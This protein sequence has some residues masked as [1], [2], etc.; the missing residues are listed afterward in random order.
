MS[1]LRSCFPKIHQT[2]NQFVQ[3]E[4]QFIHLPE[5]WITLRARAFDSVFN[6]EE[7]KAFGCSSARS[8]ERPIPCIILTSKSA[9]SSAQGTAAPPR[10]MA[11]MSNGPVVSDGTWVLTIYVTDLNIRRQFRVK[12]DMHIGGVMLRLVEDLDITRDWSDHALW[13]PQ[14]YRWLTHTRSTLDQYGVAADSMLQFTPMHKLARIQLPDLQCITM[15]VDFSV[16][17]FNAVIQL[18]KELG[19]R[20]PEELSLKRSIEPDFLSKGYPHALEKRA[21][22]SNI[23]QKRST[24]HSYSA[25]NLSLP[26]PEPETRQHYP[27]TMNSSLHSIQHASSSLSPASKHAINGM[28]TPYV[29]NVTQSNSSDWANSNNNGLQESYIPPSKAYE[30]TLLH[31]TSGSQENFD[32]TLVNSPPVLAPGILNGLFRPKNFAQKAALNQGWLDSSRSLLEQGIVEHQLILLRFKFLSFFDLNPKYDPVRINQIYEQAKWAILL[33]EVD[34]TEE[35]AF[36]FAALQLQ[37]QLR[38][39]RKAEEGTDSAVNDVDVMLNELESSLQI[40]SFQRHGNDITSVPELCDY[41]R[42]FRPKKINLKGWRRAYFVFRDLYISWYSSSSESHGQPLGRIYLKGCEVSHE[43]NLPENKYSLRLLIPSAEGMSEFWI[44]CDTEYQYARWLSACKLAVKGKTM[45][46]SSYIAEVENI[47]RLLDMQHPIASHTSSHA[48]QNVN[49]LSL[50]DTKL[51]YIRA[52]QALPEFGIHYFVVRFRH[53]PELIAIA[54]N[55]IIRMNFETGDS[56]K[57]WRFSSMKRWHV[58]WEIKRLYIQF[59]DEN[60]E[61]SCLSADCKVPHE[62]I[63]GYIFCSMRSKDQTQCLNEELFH[64]LTSGWA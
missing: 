58:N 30:S 3:I 56:L 48:H 21:S 7:P 13:W 55:R 31:E 37:V 23:S 51:Q 62:F 24:S 44:R 42:F 49:H 28:S 53:K 12:G 15:R 46:D 34:C 8:P 64:K 38:A 60:V 26:N 18:C 59:E 40:S 17:V 16:P 6:N 57:T 10:P 19:I 39:E 11:M 54:Y 47:R 43:V 22:M 1:S 14:K 50:N 9:I 25:H 20:H 29:L 32:Q 61:F 63:G 36:M 52:W 4:N 45:A 35:E 27:V 33:E 5:I 2:K 41:L